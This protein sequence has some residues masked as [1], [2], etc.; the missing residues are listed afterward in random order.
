MTV[1]GDPVSDL[2]TRLRNAQQA[3]HA[4]TEIPASNLKESILEILVDRGYLESVQRIDEGPQGV[5]VAEL[6]YDRENKGM[7]QKLR[8]VSKPSRRVYVGV[9]EIPPVLNGLGVAI[10]STSRGVMA[11]DEARANNVGGELLCTVY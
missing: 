2:L 6:R 5:L 10:L 9:E 3:R 4:H 11:G 8:R 7:I 1:V